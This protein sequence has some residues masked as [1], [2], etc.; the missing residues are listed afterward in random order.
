MLLQKN[1]QNYDWL[2]MNFKQKS[3]LNFPFL[4]EFCGEFSDFQKSTFTQRISS[5]F[6][7]FSIDLIAD[8]LSLSMINPKYRVSQKHAPNFDA[9]F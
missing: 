4:L 7:M 8:L 1:F 3:F 5:C 9:L 6:V 2:K